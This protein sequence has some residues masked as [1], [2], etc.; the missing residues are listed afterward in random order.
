MLNRIISTCSVRHLDCTVDVCVPPHPVCNCWSSGG[1]LLLPVQFWV[2]IHHPHPPHTHTHTRTHTH[3]GWTHVRHAGNPESSAVK[4]LI[5]TPPHRK[6]PWQ[7]EESANSDPTCPLLQN[8]R[9]NPSLLR[10]PHASIYLI[11]YFYKN[12]IINFCD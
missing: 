8:L 12:N 1:F 5:Y 2:C 4:G 9:L 3:T 11:L 7:H 10:S 6:A